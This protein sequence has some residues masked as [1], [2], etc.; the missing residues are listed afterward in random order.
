MQVYGLFFAFVY[1]DFTKNHV[2]NCKSAFSACKCHYFFVSLQV[3]LCRYIHVA[4][5]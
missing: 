5:I 4:R 3:E 1:T 2:M